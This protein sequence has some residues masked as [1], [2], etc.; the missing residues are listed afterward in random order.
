M[1][2]HRHESLPA[3][4]RRVWRWIR[5][6]LH[7]A[8]GA[9]LLAGGF[10]GYLQI[11][12]NFHPV[13]AGEVYRSAQPTAQDLAGY[14]KDHGI[15][16]VIN[17]RGENR[18]TDWY[19]AER[20]VTEASGVALYSFRMSASQTL[21][22]ARAQE[23]ITLMANAKKPVLIHC[24]GGADRTGLA[25]ALYL[26]AIAKAGKEAASD[27]I[28]LRYGH[29]SLPMTAAYPMDETFEALQPWLGL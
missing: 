26:A 15:R 28:S 20:A 8:L 18:G 23:L 2:I 7:S 1:P 12:G 13:I 5:R 4:R 6:G 29:I 9:G 25:S 17:L 21:D 27:Q 10:L 19:E 24:R 22:R 3:P 16:S 14:V 11:S